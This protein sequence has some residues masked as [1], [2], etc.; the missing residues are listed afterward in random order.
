MNR[1]DRDARTELDVGRD[2]QLLV[3]TQVREQVAAAVERLFRGEAFGTVHALAVFDQQIGRA[4]LPATVVLFEGRR[5]RH[6]ARRKVV[7]RQAQD[8]G[9]GAGAL[10][11]RTARAARRSS[12]ARSKSAAGRVCAAARRTRAAACTRAD[13]VCA[14][15]RASRHS[16]ATGRIT[17]AAGGG[18]RLA[19]LVPAAR[20][21]GREQGRDREH[22]AISSGRAGAPRNV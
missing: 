6:A 16:R 9:R 8:V 12:T 1:S 11:L 10:A 7:E 18:R 13:R 2:P 19:V 22:P 5:L 17:A 14:A 4:G 15:A 21:A 20:A 3:D